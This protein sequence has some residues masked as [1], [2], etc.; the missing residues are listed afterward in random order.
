MGTNQV[1]LDY[2]ALIGE[3]WGK[4]KNNLVNFI[5][6]TII[7]AAICIVLSLPRS[8]ITSLVLFIIGGPIYLGLAHMALN[9]ARDQKVEL[10]MLFSGF[11][12]FV[13]ACLAG[14]LVGIFVSI[15]TMLCI[16]PGILVSTIYMFTF[17]Y[18]AN[19]VNNFWEA[20]ESSR[21]NVMANFLPW[22]LLLLIAMALNIIGAL[23]LL[24]GMLITFPLTIILIAIS[25]DRFLVA[26]AEVIPVV[27]ETP[28]DN[29]TV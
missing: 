23:A 22:L 12:N 27:D 8:S 9:A 14:I 26:N 28:I 19:G 2:A 3:A 29:D 5:L 10:G 11:K 1:Q 25:F 7:Y 18:M 15:G 13:P 16:I 21:I 6:A 4:L 20:M 17:F 24:I